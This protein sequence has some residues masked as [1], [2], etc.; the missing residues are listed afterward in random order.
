MDALLFLVF[1]FKK[2]IVFETNNSSSFREVFFMSL[3]SHTHLSHVSFFIH[4]S[5]WIVPCFVHFLVI[6]A[7][8]SFKH[9]LFC[10]FI[11]NNHFSTIMLI[12]NY[13]SHREVMVLLILRVVSCIFLWS[14]LPVAEFFF[15]MLNL[16]SWIIWS[17]IVNWVLVLSW[18]FE[19]IVKLGPEMTENI[20]TNIHR[21]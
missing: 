15:Q 4:F 19:K 7:Y 5:S 12:N 2:L 21:L 13:Y 17:W 18:L 11:N 20:K 10:F 3:V 14:F 1:F 16:N 6:K 8:T 9:V